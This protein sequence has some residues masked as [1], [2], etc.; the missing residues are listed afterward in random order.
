MSAVAEVPSDRLEGHRCGPLKGVAEVPGDKSI[1]HRAL[2]FGGLAAGTTNIEGLLEGDDVLHTAAAVRAFGAEV[3]RL[4]DGHWRV[5]SRSEWRSPDAPIDC[6]N[7]G[8]GARLLMG[9]AAGWPIR[10]TFTGDA[11]LSGRPMERVLGPLRQMGARTEGSTLPVTVHGGTLTGI[12][13]DNVKSSAQVKTAILLAGLRA[14]GDVEV[15][16]ALPSRDHTENMLRAFGVDVE[17]EGGTVR[18]GRHRDMVATDVIVPRD[19]S[20]AAFPIVAA[21]LVPG[22]EVELPN[23]LINPLRTGLITTLKEMGGDIEYRNVRSSGG[24][25]VAD[26]IVRASTLTGVE[27]PAERAPS[28]ID[29]YPILAIAAACAGGTTIMTGLEELRVKESDRLSAVAEGLGACGVEYQEGKDSLTVR[30]AGG[31]PAGGGEVAAHHDHRIAMSFLVL[32]LVA[33]RPV[34]VDSA[35][36]IATSF[37]TFLPLMRNLGADIR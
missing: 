29:E 11:S 16:E 35:G 12:S 22:S 6:G 10:A 24:E 20:S 18:L 21:L 32:G 31:P 28:M 5:T 19:P 9:A 23:I 8:T 2:I 37:P 15:H 4:G 26:I 3:E 14:V 25:Q 36:M 34:A 13:Y 1:S 33:E 17:Q 27:V 30:G 7:S